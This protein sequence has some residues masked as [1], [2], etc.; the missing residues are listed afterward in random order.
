M[1]FILGVHLLV[2]STEETMSTRLDEIDAI[3]ALPEFDL[4]NF[5]ILGKRFFIT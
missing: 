1:I 3:M 5:C 4:K 2:H